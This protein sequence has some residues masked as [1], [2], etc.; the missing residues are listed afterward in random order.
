[1]LQSPLPG[2]GVDPPI[3]VGNSTRGCVRATACDAVSGGFKPIVPS[4]CVADRAP[5]SHKVNLFDMD[6]KYA[7]VMPSADVLDYLNGL[8]AG[9]AAAE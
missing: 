7:D 8:A 1:N 2:L 5:L 3:I 9:R 6:S 4:D